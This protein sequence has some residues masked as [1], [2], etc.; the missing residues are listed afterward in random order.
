[1]DG[2]SEG[3]SLSDWTMARGAMVVGVTISLRKSACKQRIKGH[4]RESVPCANEI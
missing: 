3:R 2:V 4:K 1:M